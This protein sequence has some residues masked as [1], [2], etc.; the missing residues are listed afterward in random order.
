MGAEKDYEINYLPPRKEVMHAYSAHDK[1]KKILG[2]KNTFTLHD[3]L[4]RM[5]DWAKKT[6]A[7]KSKDFDNIEITEKLPPSWAQKTQT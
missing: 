6:G 5:A 4:V 3:G 2:Y 1:A 7:K